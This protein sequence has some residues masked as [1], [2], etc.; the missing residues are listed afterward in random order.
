MSCRVEAEADEAGCGKPGG[1]S[2]VSG[3]ATVSWAT[4]KLKKAEG[5]AGLRG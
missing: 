4:A 3:T 5:K 1:P 2:E